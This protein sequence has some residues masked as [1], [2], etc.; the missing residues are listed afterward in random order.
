MRT[1]FKAWTEPYIKEHPEVGIDIPS[2]VVFDKPYY[3]EIGSGKGQFILDMALKNPSKTF[4]SIERNVTCAGFTAKKL[5]DNKIENAKIMWVNA[6]FVLAELKD[7]SVE[8]I[9][10]NFSDPWPKKRHAKRRLTA[11]RYLSSYYRILKPGA[12]LVIKTDQKDLYD[13][14]FEN[15]ETSSFKLISKTEDYQSLDEFDTI[16]EYEAD[17][18]KEGLPIYRIV[19]EK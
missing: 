4:I 7:N 16:T 12:R 2:L 18:R 9:F 5:V 10:L 19:L 1:K 11:D 3:L 6:D 17:F 8:G 13:F 15:L 14:T